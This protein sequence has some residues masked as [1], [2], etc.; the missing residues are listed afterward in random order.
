MAASPH[1]FKHESVQ[2]PQSVVQYLQALSE[3]LK[4]G[5]LEFKTGETELVVAPQG[6]IKFSIKVKRDGK[7][8]RV[9][10]RL[11][12]KERE[13]SSEAAGSSRPRPLI[14]ESREPPK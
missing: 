5:Q 13:E 8:I 2:D 14:I 1:E 3:G 9:T 4:K 10:T 12:W 6:L 7:R 11:S